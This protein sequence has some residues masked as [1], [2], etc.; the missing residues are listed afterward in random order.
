MPDLSGG[1]VFDRL[2]QID[3][4]ARVLLSSGY[5]VDGKAAEILDR[6]CDDFIQ[7]PFDLRTLS[8]KVEG[9]LNPDRPS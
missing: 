7:K 6:G 9:L 3:E 2:K 8:R 5:T 1:E 4:G